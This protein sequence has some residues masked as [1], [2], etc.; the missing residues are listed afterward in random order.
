M[1]IIVE[2]G[3]KRTNLLGIAGW[4]VFLGILA[5]AAYYIFFVSPE[6]VPIAAT[7]SLSTIAPIANVN[8]NPQTIVGSAQFQSLQSNIALPTPQSPNGVGRPNPF[9]AP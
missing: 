9:I 5:V 4:V 2:E 6:L 7:G 3:R 8:L 1:A